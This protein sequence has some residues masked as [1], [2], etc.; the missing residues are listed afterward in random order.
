MYGIH[1]DCSMWTVPWNPYGL[2]H[3]ECSMDSIWTGPWIPYGIVHGFTI[4]IQRALH[5]P[6]LS[7]WNPLESLWIFGVYVESMWIF[8]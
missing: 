1:M 2:V 6:I 8:L 5:C 7:S 3:V 4:K